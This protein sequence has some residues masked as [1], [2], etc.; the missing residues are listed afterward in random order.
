MSSKK[1]RVSKRTSNAP[2]FEE[3]NHDM[4]ITLETSKRYMMIT[5]NKTFIKE[6]GFEHPK[7][8][9][10]KDIVNKGRKELCRPPK[11]AII[12][13]VREFYAN[14]VDQALKRV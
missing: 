9:F 5:R 14:L 6:K 8:F 3:Y 4:F 11:L 7:D 12:L 2:P 10:K 13:V 1:Q